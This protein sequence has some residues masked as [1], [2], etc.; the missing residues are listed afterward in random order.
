M[1][2]DVLED[3]PAGSGAPA[4]EPVGQPARERGARR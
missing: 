2:C 1:H 4:N 3:Q